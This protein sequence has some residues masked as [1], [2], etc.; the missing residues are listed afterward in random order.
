[1]GHDLCVIRPQML[2]YRLFSRDWRRKSNRLVPRQ[3][4]LNSVR[5]FC[6]RYARLPGKMWKPYEAGWRYGPIASVARALSRAKPFDLIY[7]CELMPD[8]VV[9]LRLG[10]ELGLP[11]MLS[12]IGSDAHTYPYQSRRAMRQ[13]VKALCEADLILVEA[14]GAI[15]DIERLSADTAPVRCFNRGIDLSRFENAVTRDE[16][17]RELGLPLNRQLVVFVGALNE[18]K[19]IR[20]LADAFSLVTRQ[21][22]NVD[23]VCVGAGPLLTWLRNEAVAREWGDKL[24]LTG[25]R[26]F[27]EVPHILKACDVFCLPSY[28]EGLPKSVVEGMAAGLPV[29]VT[30]VGG[31][32][33][34]MKYG[35]C[36]VLVPAR[37]AHALA[38]A[39]V[40]L[41][42]N[43]EMAARMG[44][45]GRDIAYAHFD[46]VKNATG[47]LRFAEEAVARGQA[48]LARE[49]RT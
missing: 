16:K 29:V 43:A 19:G 11:V 7:G 2:F 14:Q 12:S 39:L 20:T 42:A 21:I 26:A 44:R 37:D 33:D 47:I 4:T 5:V 49:K 1:M 32:P 22:A 48:R 10:Q 15:G 25:R 6:P 40:G 36:G 23:L 8:G 13:T 28:A 27:T 46:T 45:T 38:A 17:R 31:I 41:L 34:V 3:Y 18:G 30:S 35:E 24:H 9:A